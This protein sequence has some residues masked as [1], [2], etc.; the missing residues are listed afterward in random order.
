MTVKH[1]GSTWRFDL[2]KR[3][4]DLILSASALLLLSPLMA[5]IALAIR[6]ELG[7]PVLFRQERPG[8]KGRPFMMLKFRTMRA[9]VT[10]DGQS[11]PDEERISRLGSLL[12]RTSLDELPEA[13]NILMGEMS[14][15][16]PRPLLSS[17]LPYYSDEQMRRHDAKPG[18]TG[19]SQVHGRRRVPFQQRLAQ[20]V[21]YVDHRS[22]RLDARIIFM[23]IGQVLRG[24]GAEPE[25]FLSLSELGFERYAQEQR[26][27]VGTEPD[28][29]RASDPGPGRRRT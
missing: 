22:L 27:S 2:A 14:I 10:G 15:V 29:T 28:E 17:Y 18:L 5:V 24:S 26:A 7:P 25:R 8:Y 12:R 9:P 19:W 21:W 4:I 3:A 23:T 11:V 1:G 16:G 13:W 20:D 6:I